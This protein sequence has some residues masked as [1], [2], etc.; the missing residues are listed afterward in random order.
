MSTQSRLAFLLPLLGFGVLLILAFLGNSA[1]MA[2][3]ACGSG[4]ALWLT[5]LAPLRRRVAAVAAGA[6]L[7]S[8]LAE[9]V[10]TIYHLLGG[11]TASGDDGFFFMSAVMVGAINA[12]VMALLVLAGHHL[13]LSVARR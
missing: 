2:V 10:H 12:G 13:S 11:E 1:V 8:L 5:R 3:S 6:I 9:T 7:A 4:V